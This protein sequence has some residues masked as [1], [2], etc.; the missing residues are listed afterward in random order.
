MANT[1]AGFNLAPDSRILKFAKVYLCV[2]LKF[3]NI[4]KDLLIGLVVWVVKILFKYVY[5]KI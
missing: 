5:T 1:L 3:A 2:G 4:A